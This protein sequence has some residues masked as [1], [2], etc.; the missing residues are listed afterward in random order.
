MHYLPVGRVK[1][2]DAHSKKC[3]GK[4]DEDRGDSL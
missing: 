4:T 1:E 3:D 2:K